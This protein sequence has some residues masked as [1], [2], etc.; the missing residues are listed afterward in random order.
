M[1]DEI[2]QD[3]LFIACTRPPMLWGVPMQAAI[4]NGMAV[5]ILFILVKNPLYLPIGAVT[6]WL[7]RQVVSRDYN[8]FSVWGLW[9]VT[10]ARATDVKRWGGS[11]I[12]PHPS[13]HARS[14]R[15][16]RVYD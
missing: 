4:Y 8:M 16:I 1:A 10:K 6:H 9:S 2:T 14:R 5:M 7:M 11:S 13:Q 3:T 15:E 12:S